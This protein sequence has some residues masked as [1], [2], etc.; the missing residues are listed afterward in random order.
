MKSFFMAVV[1]LMMINLAAAQPREDKLFTGDRKITV[2]VLDAETQKP[3]D[4]VRIQL[5]G[6]DLE[7]TT[8]Y[9]G[10]FILEFDSAK[11]TSLVV[12][13]PDYDTS[14]VEL[15]TKPRLNILLQ[16]REDIR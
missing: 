14:R 10:F 4:K 15:T 5:T 8:N 16:R 3:I 2:R 6:S 1:A 9:I 7:T 13:H 11:Y 12:S